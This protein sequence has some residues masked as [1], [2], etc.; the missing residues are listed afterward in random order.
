MDRYQHAKFLILK[1]KLEVSLYNYLIQNACNNSIIRLQEYLTV[2]P[3]RY[4]LQYEV[5][6]NNII[7][8]LYILNNDNNHPVTVTTINDT[9]IN[10]IETIVFNVQEHEEL[11]HCIIEFIV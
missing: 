2:I 3:Q 6:I 10:I 9:I 11:I 4:Q 8:Q 7:N 5:I 1:R